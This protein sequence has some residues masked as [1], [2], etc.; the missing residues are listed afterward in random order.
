MSVKEVSLK[1]INPS[2]KYLY[3]VHKAEKSLREVSVKEHFTVIISN[4]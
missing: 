1:N 3:N 2:R 4:L